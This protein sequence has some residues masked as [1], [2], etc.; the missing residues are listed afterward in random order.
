MREL[1]FCVQKN[2]RA[3]ASLPLPGQEEGNRYKDSSNPRE[4]G[5]PG[6]Y[7]GGRNPRAQSRVTVPLCVGALAEVEEEEAEGD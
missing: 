6:P 4:P 7:K 5:E 1:C 2:K 3:P